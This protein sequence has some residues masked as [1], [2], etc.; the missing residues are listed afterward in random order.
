[1]I[2]TDSWSTLPDDAEADGFTLEETTIGGTCNHTL[3]VDTVQFDTAPSAVK[4]H[5][6]HP[7]WNAGA[8]WLEKVIAGFPASAAY[9]M[10]TRLR[11]HNKPWFENPIMNAGGTS[12]RVG[13]LPVADTWGDFLVAGHL[14]AS[15]IATI[16]FGMNAGSGVGE[17]WDTWFD[18]EIHL[19]VAGAGETIIRFRD[20][21]VCEGSG[22]GDGAR[23]VLPC[24]PSR[25][26]NGRCWRWPTSGEPRRLR[27]PPS[28]RSR[29]G[30]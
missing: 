25:Q 5:V 1:V 26:I 4:F 8:I 7:A 13:S 17:N 20:L 28:S 27:S 11:L 30:P 21:G 14:P 2:D 12:G 29:S 10:T 9:T 22:K 3:A 15:G 23:C 16:K 19:V 6:D 18:G 24:P